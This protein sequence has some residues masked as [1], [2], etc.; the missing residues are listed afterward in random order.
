M[1]SHVFSNTQF[2]QELELKILESEFEFTSNSK[3]PL[4]DSSSKQKQEAPSSKQISG[5]LEREKKKIQNKFNL[6]D[7]SEPSL[8]TLIN[9]KS[10]NIPISASSTAKKMKPFIPKINL[11]KIRGD[12]SAIKQFQPQKHW[13]ERNSFRRAP[14]QM[15][16]ISGMKD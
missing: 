6:K 9:S 14:L 1:D 7:Y 16:S 5:S 8:N 2:N 12:L 4:L 10:P 13:S 15:D 11:N 3:P